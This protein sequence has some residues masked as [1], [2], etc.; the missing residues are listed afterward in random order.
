MDA[1]RKL[2]REGHNEN[3][4]HKVHEKKKCVLGIFKL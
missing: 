2:I 3:K 1:H 4:H